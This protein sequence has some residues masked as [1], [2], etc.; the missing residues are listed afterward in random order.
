[1]E[2]RPTFRQATLPVGQE[3]GSRPV[4]N[5]DNAALTR[6][7]TGKYKSWTNSLLEPKGRQHSLRA[8]WDRLD[9]GTVVLVR[10]LLADPMAEYKNWTELDIDRL[11]PA[12]Y[13]STGDAS[14]SLSGCHRRRP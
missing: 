4:A 3:V 2:R 1:M 9:T 11:D 8:C 13:D 10:R 6:D 7:M 12:K 14:G 5:N